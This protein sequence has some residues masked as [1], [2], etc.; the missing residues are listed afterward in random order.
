MAFLLGL[1]PLIGWGTGDIFG[2]F[3]SRKV[4]SYNTT[5]YQFFFGIILCL[6]LLPYFWSDVSKI[7]APLLILNIVLGT[8]YVG[9]NVLVNEAFKHSNASIVG[10]I[11]QSFPAVVLILS[12]IIFNDSLSG[13]QIVWIVAVFAGM[14]LCSVDLKSLKEQSLSFDLGIKYSLIASLFFAV[15]FT[16]FRLFSTQYNWFL[17]NFIAFLT[18]PLAIFLAK[19]FLK[20]E[21]TLSIPKDKMIVGALLISSLLIRSGDIAL[22]FGISAGF[23]AT[24]APLAGASP[25]LFVIVS[26]LFFKDKATKQQIA[27][28]II[29]LLGIVGLSL[30]V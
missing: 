5:F 23:A 9:S 14:F 17:P 21:D 13:L 28:V 24:V 2:A 3:S 29:S 1:I 7:T 30:W 27:G 12:K 8:F 11:I 16:F 15:Y 22:N 18:L 10:V 20:L 25:V 6:F 19:K 4:G 26:S